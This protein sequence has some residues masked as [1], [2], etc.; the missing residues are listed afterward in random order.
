MLKMKKQSKVKKNK[1][2]DL[3]N[4]VQDEILLPQSHPQVKN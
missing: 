2:S 4:H 1:G 3:G